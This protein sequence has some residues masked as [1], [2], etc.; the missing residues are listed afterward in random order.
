MYGNSKIS[1]PMQVTKYF[2]HSLS[3]RLSSPSMLSFLL[4]FTVYRPHNPNKLCL[5]LAKAKQKSRWEGACAIFQRTE[6]APPF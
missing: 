2:C 3:F 1:I 5:R 4:L 6:K